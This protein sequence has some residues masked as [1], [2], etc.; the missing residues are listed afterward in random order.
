MLL[1]TLSQILDAKVMV[2]EDKLYREVYYCC[3]SDL[4]SDVLAYVTQKVVLLT[5]LMN[6]QVVRTA[7]MMD[8]KTI[9]FVRG[10]IP[11]D[12]IL[13]LAAAK[14]IVIMYTDHTLFTACGLLYT[15][16]LKGKDEIDETT[17]Q[18]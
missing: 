9:V 16:G 3:G 12:N 1:S 8:I 17:L 5:G 13:K 14:D 2:G 7:E 15:N 18:S 4:M 11:S 10:K 6:M